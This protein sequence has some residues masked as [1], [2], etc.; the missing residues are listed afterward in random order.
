MQPLQEQ[1][2]TIAVGKVCGMDFHRQ[3]QA[4]GVN[5]NV[6][7]APVDFFSRDRSLFVHHE[8]VRS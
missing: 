2:S 1:G 8:P 3:E 7:L 5:Q 6:P 4:L